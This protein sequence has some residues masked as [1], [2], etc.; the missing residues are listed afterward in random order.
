MNLKALGLNCKINS[1][2]PSTQTCSTSEGICKTLPGYACTLDIQCSSFAPTCHPTDGY[3]TKYV[4]K[5]RGTLGNPVKSDG[6]CDPPNIV[7]VDA[8][9]C[10][11]IIGATCLHDEDCNQGLCSPNT[12]TYTLLCGGDQTVNPNQCPPGLTCNSTL[13]RCQIG[14]IPPGAPG[15]ACRVDA[16]CIGTG[17]KCIPLQNGA[18]Y[19]ICS[20]GTLSFLQ[21]SFASPTG[22]DE[23]V[24]YP[25]LSFDNSG[26]CKY[27]VEQHMFCSSISQCQYP[28]TS[29]S[30]HTV[31][32]L[33]S[34]TADPLINMQPVYL[35]V[36]FTSGNVGNP[37]VLVRA[38]FAETK[39]TINSNVPSSLPGGQ[40]D[41]TG[42]RLIKP[43]RVFSSSDTL[44][45]HPLM[46]FSRTTSFSVATL[47]PPI[48]VE[49]T[50][51][52]DDPQPVLCEISM[53]LYSDLVPPTRLPEFHLFRP[54]DIQF[55]FQGWGINDSTHNDIPPDSVPWN[56]QLANT[57]GGGGQ[58]CSWIQN[59]IAHHFN[60]NAKYIASHALGAVDTNAS[61]SYFVSWNTY[62]TLNDNTIR[63]DV[64]YTQKIPP[65]LYVRLYRHDIDAY[66]T[67]ANF[68]ILDWD[69][70]TVITSTPANRSGTIFQDVTS[71]HHTCAV[72][73]FLFFGFDRF[74]LQPTH[75]GNVFSIFYMVVV[76]GMIG[77]DGIRRTFFNSLATDRL[78]CYVYPVSTDQLSWNQ[79]SSI[80]VSIIKNFQSTSPLL[81]FCAFAPQSSSGTGTQVF[82]CSL[83]TFV[84]ISP[85]SRTPNIPSFQPASSNSIL[86]CQNFASSSLNA[87]IIT[88]IAKVKFVSS[89]TSSDGHG[90]L[91]MWGS[92][93]TGASGDIMII[94]K[95]STS[96]IN[97]NYITALEL[98]SIY[99][100]QYDDPANP[101][102]YYLYPI[103]GST[104]PV[105]VKSNTPI[106]FTGIPP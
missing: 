8:R 10:Q 13:G 85:D 33:P 45:D 103:G 16:E 27:I 92:K 56:H 49:N 57:L 90:C 4:D 91:V 81:T 76:V 84:N 48:L 26:F 80:R 95:L 23:H 35:D 89:L 74:S 97:N 30:D 50:V 78:A 40:I 6:T 5:A 24:C 12:C 87:L 9:L 7:N 46:S 38:E 54:G 55:N 34:P 51:L 52:E 71:D 68:S 104:L 60:F 96:C 70:Y 44:P 19:G 20:S 75:P 22:G 93:T 106:D 88:G 63:R 28:Y 21:M 79:T 77:H 17:S 62:V 65:G 101:P 11:G 36:Y 3:C 86:L 83:D 99:W 59:P 58:E 102:Q 43:Y 98:S 72:I 2:C 32:R 105:F 39:G 67:P 41:Y 1:D 18:A 82:L 29:C 66:M 37:A 42:G 15:S 53:I 31:C 47:I 64:R 14:N 25:P 73:H 69:A 61:S 94:V 100:V